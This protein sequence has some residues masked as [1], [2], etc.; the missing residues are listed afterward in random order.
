MSTNG[1][2][3]TQRK[4]LSQPMKTYTKGGTFSLWAVE[5]E[6]PPEGGKRLPVLEAIIPAAKRV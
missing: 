2:H 4:L 6:K 1:H 5:S 3:K